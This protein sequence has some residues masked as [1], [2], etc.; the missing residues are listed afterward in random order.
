[1]ILTDHIPTVTHLPRNFNSLL[2]NFVFIWLVCVQTNLLSNKILENFVCM[3]RDNDLIAYATN[4]KLEIISLRI[5]N[6]KFTLRNHC[7]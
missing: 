5:R 3:H 6:K 2:I 7:A 1:M 4:G